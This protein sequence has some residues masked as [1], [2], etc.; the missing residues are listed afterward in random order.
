YGADVAVISKVHPVRSHSNAAQG[1]I[2]AAFGEHEDDT[3]ELHAYDTVKG[4]D[5]LGDQDA[6]EVMAKEAP[7]D[8]IDLEHMGVVFNRDANGK[9]ATR[10]FGGAT[11]QRTFFV[12]DITGQALLQVMYEQCMKEQVK[13]YEEW[14]A[15]SLVIE[16][17]AC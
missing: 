6:I 11:K 9:L 13:V 4:S 5:W 7:G 14:F 16:D 1:G 8:I 10:A 12:A 3:W 17:G 15:L 2:N